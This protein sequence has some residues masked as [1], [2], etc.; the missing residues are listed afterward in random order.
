MYPPKIQPKVSSTAPIIHRGELDRKTL[1]FNSIIPIPTKTKIIIHNPRIQYS[2]IANIIFLKFFISPILFC[3]PPHFANSTSSP[4]LSIIEER[5][6]SIMEERENVK[7]RFWDFSKKKIGG[8]DFGEGKQKLLDL[9]QEQVTHLHL[10]E[11]LD[12]A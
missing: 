8:W 1:L 6:L 11:I 9:F 2:P 3:L 12:P 5:V 7:G 4:I 10:L